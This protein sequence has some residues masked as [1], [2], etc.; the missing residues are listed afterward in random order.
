MDC[1][2]FR[3]RPERDETL[4]CV[5]GFL[6][7]ARS[8][9]RVRARTDGAFVHSQSLVIP[10]HAGERWEPAWDFDA[11]V[12]V[13]EE[14]VAGDRNVI[15]GYSMGARLALSMLLAAPQRYLGAVLVGV[16]PGIDDTRAR[17]ERLAWERAMSE[18]IEREGLDR[19]AEHWESLPVFATQ[20]T[21]PDEVRAEL[22]ARRAQH[23][24]DAMAWAMR[25][26]GTGAMPSRWSALEALRAPVVLLTG[27][28]DEKFTEIARRMQQRNARIAHRVIARRGH[29]LTIEAPEEV[30]QAALD[31]REEARTE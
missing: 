17:H 5:H 29:D 15:V 1:L 10:G 31:V 6:G 14:R 2:Y 18:R 25:A 12:R 30:A 4:V 7:D 8:F 20:A 26:L 28:R 13:L 21:L 24:A 9:D 11:A 3:S 27:E 19:F 22:R 16:D 23:R